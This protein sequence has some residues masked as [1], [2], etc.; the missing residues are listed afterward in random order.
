MDL[1]T[2][3]AR[4]ERSDNTFALTLVITSQPEL[5]AI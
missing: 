5:E 1:C 2:L 3:G 4:H